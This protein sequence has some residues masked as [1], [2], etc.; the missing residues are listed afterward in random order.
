MKIALGQIRPRVGKAQE[1]LA[2]H[3]ECI[4]AAARAGADALFFP[5]LSLTGYEPGAAKEL[6][7]EAEA[8]AVLPLAAMAQEAEI[9]VAVGVPTQSEQG[10]RI[11]MA[12]YGGEAGF[13]LYHKQELHADELLYFA[14]GESTTVYPIAG[15]R[16]G[17]GICYETTLP[18]HVS[19]TL[20]T[21]VSAY[22]ACVAK[23]VNGVQRVGKFYAETARQ[24]LTPILMVNSVG[25]QD[26]FVAGGG[27]AIWDGS[28]EQLASLGAEQEGL[29]IFDVKNHDT[30]CVNL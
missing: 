26:D 8:L 6:A 21:G 18:H 24:Y 1:S 25:A 3:G 17:L 19:T 11:S 2:R 23:S 15:E 14:A 27:S 9:F 20:E 13:Q 10:V 30:Q 7:M 16:L 12:L 22:V 5:E 29:L 28:G 4:A